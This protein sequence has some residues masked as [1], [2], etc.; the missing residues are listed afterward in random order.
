M[1]KE[2]LKE[3]IEIIFTKCET[4]LQFKEEVLKLVDLY[5]NEDDDITQNDNK[6]NDDKLNEKVVDDHFFKM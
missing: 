5:G 3:L 6:L 1:K 2:T 4:I